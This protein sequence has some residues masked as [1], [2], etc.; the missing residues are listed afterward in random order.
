MVLDLL[1]NNRLVVWTAVFSSAVTLSATLAYQAYVSGGEE[2]P[3]KPIDGAVKSVPEEV[4]NEQ[5][6]RNRAFLGD[7]AVTKIR[8]SFVVVVGAGGV[9]S[10][11]ATMLVRSG[12]GR[13]RIIDFDQVSLSSLNRHACA[14]Q[15]DVGTSKVDCIAKYLSS[16]APFVQIEPVTALWNMDGAAE[17]LEGNPDFVIDAID[18]IDTKV[19]LLTYCHRNGLQVISAMGAGCKADPTRVRLADISAS[20]EDPLSRST[21][22]RLR[23]RGISTGVPVVFSS[24]KP[25][26]DKAQILSLDDSE[27]DRGDVGELAVLPD[28]RVR[29]LPV[30]GPLPAIFGLT[31]ATHII[32]SLGDYSPVFDQVQGGY[33]MAGKARHKLY[34]GALHGLVG[35]FARLDMP[36]AREVP[37]T[38]ADAEYLIEE[39]FRGRSPISGDPNR[40]V[41]SVWDPA[42]PVNVSNLI[43]VTKDQQAYHEKTVLKGGTSLSEAYSRKVINTVQK[44]LE[45][46][47]WY[48]QFR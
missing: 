30:L 16:V 35:Q 46:E 5:L 44:R 40:L 12:V 7:E 43:P 39:V 17:L 14:T 34:D 38:V 33:S 3:R 41:L 4:I 24:E 32:N 42:L 25:G 31:V 19:D 15:A 13:V 18:N 26:K 28:F 2:K 37:I 45:E 48:R 10:W 11:A 47:K 9:G 29:I 1:S 21:R 20:A 36:Q 8:K 6:A 22:R 23:A 27:K